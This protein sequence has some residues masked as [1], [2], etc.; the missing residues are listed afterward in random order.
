MSPWTKWPKYLVGEKLEIGD[1]VRWDRNDGK[2][3]KAQNPPTYGELA[4]AL[5]KIVEAYDVGKADSTA[6][7]ELIAHARKVLSRVL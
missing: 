2:I 3:Y 6:D 7:P 4:R 5:Q 1:A